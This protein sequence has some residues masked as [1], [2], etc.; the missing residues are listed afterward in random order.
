M[1]D[2]ELRQY[3]KNQ[4]VVRG[5]VKEGHRTYSAFHP[6][7]FMRKL[8]SNAEILEHIESKP[9]NGKWLPQDIWIIKKA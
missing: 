6:P 2:P 8:F 7:K 3:N 9:E 5:N 4:L 1:T